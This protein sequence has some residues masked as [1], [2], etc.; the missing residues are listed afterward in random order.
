MNDGLKDRHRDAIIALLAANDRVEKAVLFGSRAME[1]GTD[2]SDIDIALF[3]DRLS[4]T[5]QARLA[6]AIDE[7]PMAQSVDLVL[8]R[9]IDHQPLLD[10]IRTHGIEWYRRPENKADPR[11]HLHPKH[12]RMLED[13]LREHL[14]DVEVWAYGSRVNGR[15]HDGSDLDLVLRGPGLKEIPASRLTD[16][17]EAVRES[18]IPFPVEAR[19]WTRL[20]ERFHREIEREYVVLDVAKG[21]AVGGSKS[22]QRHGWVRLNIGRV[23]SKIG[24]GAT[25]RGGKDSYLTSGPYALIRSQNVFN[26]GFRSE[27]LAHIGQLQASKLKNVEV[28]KDD[29]LLNI[30]GDSVARVCQVQPNILPAR[31]NQHVAIIRPDPAR[32]DP[33]FLRY[34]LV[35]PDMQ[36]KLLSWAGSGG[37]R[38][39]LTKGMIESLD[40]VA[41]S[42]PEQRAIAHILGTLD[43]KIE[44]N[45]RMNTTL[46]AMARAIFKDWFVD[47]GPTR[48]KA[49]G[50]EPYLAPELW[51]LFPD[52]LDDEGKPIGWVIRRVEDFLE[53]AY[54]KSLPAKKRILGKIPVYGSGGLTG[55]HDTALAEGPAVIV[56][57]KGTVGSLYWEDRP[58]FPIDTVFYVVPRIGSVLF[59]YHLLAALPLR[60]MNTDAAVPG[61]NRKNAYRLQFPQPASGLIAAFE[62]FTHAIWQ[63]RAKN[64]RETET[65]SQTRDLLLPKLM[66]GEIRIRDAENM[67]EAVT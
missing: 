46:E 40:I 25:P 30:T 59:S 67:V 38:N 51:N 52:A 60:D 17:E 11:L 42:L 19:D 24:S 23:C 48:A 5:D 57:R 16:F 35:T 47:F 58:V 15:S 27:G 22:L 41:P 14:P 63:R 21:L 29:I 53:L 64:L 20:P 7:I 49:E 50:R 34:L 44:L 62:N 45:R 61:L 55:M 1:T 10:H 13:L 66:S 43:D 36:A 54:G 65:L 28:E 4:L 6:A 9:T 2:T 8:H 31:V 12:R 18:T 3:G 56:G 39:A 37:T 33:R 26:D 32:L